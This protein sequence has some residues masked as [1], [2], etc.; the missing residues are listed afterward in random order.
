MSPLAPGTI[1]N[2]QAA[3]PSPNGNAPTGTWFITG[4]TQQGPTGVAIPIQSM[5]DYAAYLGPRYPGGIL[6]DCL[7][8]FFADGG[9][10]AYVS[11]VVGPGAQVATVA[12]PDAD[13]VTTLNVNA[14]GVGSWG[15]EVSVVVATG[16]V[17]N[18][19]T[20]SVL[21]NGI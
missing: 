15:N 6:Y 3:S 21:L 11:R 7:S 2:I 1:V 19:Y 20:I 12:I 14:S 9:V 16:S 17:S 10:L 13:S 4:L 18:T 5:A 8:E